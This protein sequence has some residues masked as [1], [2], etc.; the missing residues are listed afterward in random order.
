MIRDAR[1]RLLT[2]QPTNIPNWHRLFYLPVDDRYIEYTAK[3]F[4]DLNMH[5]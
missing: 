1:V 3:C 2:D 5:I 4:D